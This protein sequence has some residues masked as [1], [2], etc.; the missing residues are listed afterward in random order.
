MEDW[1]EIR[2]L[3]RGEHLGVQTIARRL[4]AP[5]NTVSAALA[6]DTP[7]RYERRPT[8]SIV[9][10]FVPQIEA[11]LAQLPT[12][13]ATV[14]GQRIGWEHSTSV[15]RAKVAELRGRYLPP[16]P[17]D[18]VE[19]PEGKAVQCDLWFPPPVVPDETGRLTGPPVLTMISACSRFLM[20]MML[21]SRM[22]GDLRSGMWVLLE[23]LGGVPKM[24]LWDNE[25]GIRARQRTAAETVAFAGTL[26]TRVW[27][28]RPRDPETKGMVERANGFQRSSF[29][30][31]RSFTG[32]DDFNAQLADWL[33]IANQQ[34]VCQEIGV[35]GVG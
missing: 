6:A 3:H 17:A 15:L 10:P 4:G 18:R 23:D 13:P 11:L 27:Q 30:P 33:T 21:P 2:R 16:D 35:T 31:G 22:G 20:A 5:R 28:A 32:P 25:A 29:L 26:G 19:W 34:R 14:I 9:D 1:A 7:P 24:L 8:G 12:M